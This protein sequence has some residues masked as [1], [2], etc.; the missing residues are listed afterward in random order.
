M[1]AKLRRRRSERVGVRGQRSKN[2]AATFSDG[3]RWRSVVLQDGRA[4]F[5]IA[6]DYMTIVRR[7][8]GIFVHMRYNSSALWII[9]TRLWVYFMAVL[10]DDR[11]RFDNNY[12]AKLH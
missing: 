9:F 6:T 10:N 4:S 2:R 8:S 1:L 5:A 7:M 11:Q 12:D 3:G